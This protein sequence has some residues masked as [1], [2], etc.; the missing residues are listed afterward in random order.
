M[1]AR[2]W[3]SQHSTAQH[4]RQTSLSVASARQ[5][6]CGY[7]QALVGDRESFSL[8]VR[9]LRTAVLACSRTVTDDWTA[10]AAS[11]ENR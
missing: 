7:G 9:I 11:T 5:E 10:W 6:G 4:S 8:A 2:D 3:L 1:P